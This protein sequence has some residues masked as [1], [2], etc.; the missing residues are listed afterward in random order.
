MGVVTQK[1]RSSETSGHREQAPRFVVRV[2]ALSRLPALLGVDNGLTQPCE[3]DV[4][5]ALPRLAQARLSKRHGTEV[6]EED[7]LVSAIV[8]ERKELCQGAEHHVFDPPPRLF[9]ARH[10]RLDP[11]LLYLQGSV[12]GVG[13]QDVLGGVVVLHQAHRDTRTR[14]DAAHRRGLGPVTGDEAT[15]RIDD[16]RAT[17]VVV[18]GSRHGLSVATRAQ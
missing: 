5:R 7:R 6:V 10:E 15:H 17:S 18:G 9:L 16:L 11:P 13:E 12:V 2:D 1:E 14:R 8:V 4:V 3:Q